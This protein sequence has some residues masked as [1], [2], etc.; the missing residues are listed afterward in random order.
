MDG[1]TGGQPPRWKGRQLDAQW[2][3]RWTGGHIFDDATLI[4]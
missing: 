2:V 3:R 4:Q 1:P